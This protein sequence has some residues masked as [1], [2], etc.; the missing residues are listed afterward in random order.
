MD[1]TAADRLIAKLKE[2]ATTLDTDE[3][4]LLG[5]LLA[6]GVASAY[7]DQVEV[8]GF[9]LVEWSPGALAESLGD[10]LS[11][12]GIAVTGFEPVRGSDPEGSP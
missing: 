2:F 11:R 3:R 6:P 10:A 7:A 5:V 4:V 9:A 1:V 12:G 8:Q